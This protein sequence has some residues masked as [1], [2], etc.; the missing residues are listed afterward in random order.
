[1]YLVVL[2]CGL[3]C[4]LFLFW[5]HAKKFFLPKRIPRFHVVTVG[6]VI[7][8]VPGGPW[9]IVV[10]A[11]VV[12]SAGIDAIIV[13]AMMVVVV[14]LLLLLLLVHLLL[15]LIRMWVMMWR[16]YRTSSMVANRWTVS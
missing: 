16:K 9:I 13:H 5:A 10:V 7:L 12:S 15:T 1:M 11:I 6:V 3:F 2:V 4:R 8:I 14:V